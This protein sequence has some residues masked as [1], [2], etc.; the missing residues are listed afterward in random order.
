M[1]FSKKIIVVTLLLFA[2]QIEA[3]AHPH[4]FIE[5]EL[6]ICFDKEGINKFKVKYNYDKMFSEELKQNFDTNKNNF[7]EAS[8]IENIRTKAFSN[9]VNYSYFIHIRSRGKKIKNGDVSNFTAVITDNGVYYSFNLNT[10][11]PISKTANIYKIATYEHTYY[12]DVTY[13]HNSTKFENTDYYDYTYKVI[14]DKS[15]AYY[16]KQIYPE[17]IVLSIKKK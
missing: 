9:L 16:Y 3:L 12:L 7:F 6:T 5:T 14:E 17:T 1:K 15:Q 11:I 13:K 10:K 2:F 8:E 4:V